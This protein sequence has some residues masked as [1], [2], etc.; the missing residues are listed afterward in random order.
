MKLKKDPFGNKEYGNQTFTHSIKTRQIIKNNFGMP[1][2]NNKK[3]IPVNKG[4]AKESIFRN[5]SHVH[6]VD[7]FISNTDISATKSRFNEK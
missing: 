6:E 2:I 1:Q 7:D 3:F 5:I 4:E